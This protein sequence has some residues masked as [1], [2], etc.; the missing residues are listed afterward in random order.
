MTPPPTWMYST[1]ASAKKARFL[2]LDYDIQIL[3]TTLGES[4]ATLLDLEETAV[5]LKSLWTAKV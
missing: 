3:H 5:I 1:F 2:I 4:S